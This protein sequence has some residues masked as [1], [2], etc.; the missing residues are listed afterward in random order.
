MI[1]ALQV[2]LVNWFDETLYQRRGEWYQAAL[3]LTWLLSG[4]L[5]LRILPEM[6]YRAM[7]PDVYWQSVM[8]WGAITEP[9]IL[10]AIA[11]A[12]VL[13]G[14][15]KSVAWSVLEI[16]RLPQILI[17][18]SGVPLAWAMTTYDPNFYVEQFHATDRLLA[19]IFLV[20]SV[21]HPCFLPLLITQLYLIMGQFEVPLTNANIDKQ[22]GFELLTLAMVPP[23]LKI[24]RI[25]LRPQ[26][27]LLATLVVIGTFYLKPGLGKLVINW[28]AWEQPAFLFPHAVYQNGWLGWLSEDMQA[29][30][31]RFM[32]AGAVPMTVATIVTELGVILLAVRRRSAIILLFA[33][34][35]LH[36]GIFVS[37][38]IFF[39]KWIAIDLT[40]AAYLWRMNE[41]T[42][43]QCFSLPTGALAAF[44]MLALMPIYKAPANL[45]WYDTP[46]TPRY[47]IE[48]VGTSGTTYQVPPYRLAPFDISFAQ[49]MLFFAD[50]RPHLTAGLGGVVDLQL[51]LD[52]QQISNFEQY[53]TLL[54][55]HGVTQL[56]PERRDDFKRLLK[57]YIAAGPPSSLVMDYIPQAP[58][59]IWTGRNGDRPVFD[60]QEPIETI[61]LRRS[62]GLI[63]NDICQSIDEAVVFEIPGSDVANPQIASRPQP[64]GEPATIR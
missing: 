51:C 60:W 14:Y 33:C 9:P 39:W 24:A 28:V 21:A 30:L 42:K 22:L 50:P 6:A 15:A 44:A 46:L 32:A 59:H 37:A 48:F 19:V 56:E 20:G 5:L 11:L 29:R 64:G 17:L 52:V 13:A 58:Q 26:D 63:I 38:G 40:M 34:T 31:Y 47:S 16:G 10:A 53:Q 27:F 4:L 61:R 18:S 36:L 43:L 12:V 23:V 1:N 8:A 49:G 25:R 41:Q 55:Q 2:R 54:D 45:A 3:A 62:D 7:P 57:N 35:A